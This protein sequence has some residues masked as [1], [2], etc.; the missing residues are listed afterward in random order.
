MSGYVQPFAGNDVPPTKRTPICSCRA[1]LRRS[2]SIKAT[3][4]TSIQPSVSFPAASVSN[5]PE[6]DISPITSLQQSSAGYDKSTKVVLTSPR[7]RSNVKGKRLVPS[8]REY[9]E[10]ERFLTV[11]CS[12]VN[13]RTIG[14]IQT[15]ANVR[16][17]LI[18][19]AENAL[20]H[21]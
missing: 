6:N 13:I 21:V 10:V 4:T 11:D 12:T 8:E 16:K 20:D 7:A 17:C 18:F 14:K 15:W 19:S 3:H 1:R 9:P 5:P 2:Q